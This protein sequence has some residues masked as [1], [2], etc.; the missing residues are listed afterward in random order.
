MRTWKVSWGI[1]MGA[2]TA[3]ELVP[4]AFIDNPKDRVDY[5]F[6]ASASAIGL[7]GFILQPTTLPDTKSGDLFSH[8]VN[9]LFNLGAGLPLGLYY[10]RWTSA[11]VSILGG[12][13]I[14]EGV[15]LS[16]PRVA[17]VVAPGGMG[18]S[19]SWTW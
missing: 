16:R 9:V 1:A 4:L 3:G 2:I 17:P 10:H 11:F 8:T 6:G 12:T 19:V 5:Y 15:I 18:L 14:G 7:I 13:A